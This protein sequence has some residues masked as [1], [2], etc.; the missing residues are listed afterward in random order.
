MRP[1][2]PI[3]TRHVMNNT[4]IDIKSICSPCFLSKQNAFV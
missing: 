2:K 4:I 3:P 1:K